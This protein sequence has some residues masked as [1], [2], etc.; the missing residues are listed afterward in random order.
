[1][2]RSHNPAYELWAGQRPTDA[3]V[4]VVIG[5]GQPH[6]VAG[7]LLPQPDGTWKIEVLG[8]IQETRYA[9]QHDAAEEVYRLW[10]GRQPAP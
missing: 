9:N 2:D 7:Y 6:P 1:M 5:Q 4:S 8:Q 3:S 10:I